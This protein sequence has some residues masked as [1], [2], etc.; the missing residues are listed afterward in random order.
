M[1][2]NNLSH[3]PMATAN[4]AAAT[5]VV[6]FVACR[7]LVSIVP[8]GMF[9]LAQSWFHG[10]Q[11]ARMMTWNASPSTLVLGLVSSAVFGWIVGYVFALFYNIFTEK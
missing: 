11:L 1:A 4:A 7:L 8:G 6:I 5:T 10:V 2:K 3:D 9:T